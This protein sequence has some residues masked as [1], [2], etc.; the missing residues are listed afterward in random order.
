MQDRR[1]GLVLF[2]EYPLSSLYSLSIHPITPVL[3]VLCV[4]SVSMSSSCSLGI[5]ARALPRDPDYSGPLFTL[6]RRSFRPL[7]S[8]SVDP[9]VGCP[10]IGHCVL[11][12]PRV[13][14]L[15][16][17]RPR[18]PI[19]GLLA[20]ISSATPSYYIG[21]VGWHLVSH[22]LILSRG[23]WLASRQPHT[24]TIQGS[25]ADI[26]SATP[27]YYLGFV[28]RHLVGHALI[29]SRGRWLASRQPHPPTIQGSLVG[30]SP[31]TPSWGRWLASRQPHTSTIQGSLADISSATPSYYLGFVGRAPRRPRPHIIKGSLAGISSA[32]P[33]YYPGLVGWHLAS[34][35]LILSR[36]RWSAR[37]L[38]GH[39]LIHS[40]FVGRS[41]RCAHTSWVGWSARWVHWLAHRLSSRALIHPRVC[42]LGSSMVSLVSTPSG[43]PLPHTF[44]VS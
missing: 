24:S 14:W 18:P 34:H 36:V 4:N 28:G 40:G 16:S 8:F 43:W 27:S 25:L 29:L 21:F 41:G 6:H 10:F 17:R 9:I 7:P 37:R 19:Q 1:L 13:C 20:D 23:R 32:T 15:A 5:C 38:A 22:T 39:V 33:S 2:R 31:A 35:V 26:S 11:P 30:T 42:W 12:H 44:R 3:C